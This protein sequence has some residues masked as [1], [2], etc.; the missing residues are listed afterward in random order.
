MGL[1]DNLYDLEWTA[2]YPLHYYFDDG[3]H[4][5]F[6]KY[7]I[8]MFGLIFNKKTDRLLRYKR[9]GDYNR[10]TVYYNDK[11]HTIFVARAVVST[12][13]GK[14]PTS[15]HS[16]EHIDNTNKINDIVCEL[17]W[18]DL[19]GQ[20]KNRKQPK[21]YLSAQI[22]VRDGL[23][24]TAKEWVKYLN[25]TSSIV[26]CQY[27]VGMITN[28]AQSKSHGFSYKV[29]EDLPNERWYHIVNSDTTRGHWEISDKN[30]IARVSKFGR[31]VLDASRFGFD[32][33]YPRIWINGKNRYLHDVAFEAYY[34]EVYD[35]KMSHEMI[36][37]KLDDK[38]D[39]RP[40]LLT[41]G[42]GSQNITDAY[43]NG[44]RDE[45]KNA[46]VPCMSFINGVFEKRFES[47]S[48]AE[49]YLKKMGFSKA[50]GTAIGTALTI[51]RDTNKL[52]TR[53]KRT[54]RPDI[55]I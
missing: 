45:S 22:V 3:R 2:R 13:L 19:P 24:L 37:H 54:W 53:Y 9:D 51:L 17:T 8:D 23:E 31:N 38:L 52:V 30:R 46:R 50:D 18:I 49:K 4:I 16:T 40:H 5:I 42:D 41:I 27:T 39:F 35:A 21:T 47:Q 25:E 44:H 7:E 55:Q 29:Y 11:P 12:F 36:L 26:N 28:Y 48:D 32:K 1:F 43:D 6:E 14:P 34:P 15:F 20:G 33:K 10:V